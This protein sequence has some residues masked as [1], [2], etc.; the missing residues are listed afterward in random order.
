M[1]NGPRKRDK[2]LLVYFSPAERSLVKKAAG[3][4]PLGTWLRTLALHEA[5]KGVKR[6]AFGMT[7]AEAVAVEENPK[8]RRGGT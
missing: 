7:P 8:L 2:P 6:G 5:Q 1:A 3:D 4:H